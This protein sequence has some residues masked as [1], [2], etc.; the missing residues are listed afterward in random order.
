MN[1]TERHEFIM[2][3]LESKG[4]V[5]VTELSVMLNVSEVTIRKDLSL[6]ERNNL[7][8]RAHG[9]A[10]KI[11][12]YI[13]DRDVNVKE[14][15]FPNEK[16]A[17]GKQAVKLIEPND[18][19][20]IASGTTV[21]YFAREINVEQGRLTVITS[22]LNVASVLSKSSRIEVIQLGGII[23]GSSLSAVGCDAERM[24][25][26]FTGSKLFIGVDGIDPEHGLSTTNLLEANLNRAMI[27]SAQKTIVLCDSSK[28]DRRGFSRICSIDEIDQIITDSGISQHMLS[29]LRGRGIEVTVVEV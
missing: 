13:N 12:P 23:R 5:S 4:W 6:L 9:K 17:I 14:H 2:R 10:I 19:I 15:Q 1:I 16:I 8:Y 3:E 22:A 29:T 18:S 7:L 24:L 11:S 27:N 26:N 21:Q 25:E 20:I 28:F